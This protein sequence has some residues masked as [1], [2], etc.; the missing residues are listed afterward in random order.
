MSNE[1]TVW[2]TGDKIIASKLNNTGDNIEAL[3]EET[4]E[5][6]EKIRHELDTQKADKTELADLYIQTDYLTRLAKENKKINDELNEE[7]S[8]RDE[9]IAALFVDNDRITRTF[10][11]IQSDIA[12]LRDHVYEHEGELNEESESFIRDLADVKANNVEVENIAIDVD[13]AKRNIEALTEEVRRKVDNEPFSALDAEV[14][15]IQKDV[16]DLKHVNDNISIER[17]NVAVDQI[18][19]ALENKADKM[20][21]GASRYGE[22]GQLY[23]QVDENKRDIK[24]KVGVDHLAAEIG[25]LHVEADELKRSNLSQ[26]SLISY[27]REGLLT[28]NDNIAAKVPKPFIEGQSGQLLSTNGDGTTTWITPSPASDEQI[29]TAVSD[30]LD[31]HPDAT[32][33][34]Q[35]GSITIDK[36][37]PELIDTIETS[38]EARDASILI[39][40]IQSELIAQRSI[41]DEIQ[42]YLLT[43]EGLHGKL[44]Q[45]AGMFNGGEGIGFIFFTDP[46]CIDITFNKSNEYMLKNLREIRTV[47]ENS[48]AR[49]ILCGGDWINEKYTYNQAKLYS[50]RIVNLMRGWLG[51]RSYTCV[52]NHDLGFTTGSSRYN[53][54]DEKELANMWYGKNVGYFVIE[55]G[56]ADCY[57]LDSGIDNVDSTNHVVLMYEYRWIQL[58]WFA[59]KLLTN[60]SKH[61]FGAIHIPPIFP[62]TSG[63][64]ENPM[65]INVCAIADAF[66]RRAS[67]TINEN[68][69]DFS[70]ATGTFHF[71]V[72]GHIHSDRNWTCNNI[73]VFSSRAHL[74]EQP[75]DCCYADF[76]ASVLHMLRIG[77]GNSRDFNIIPSGQYQVAAG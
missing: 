8:M 59:N 10:D 57:V 62:D 68:T 1:R 56:N 39:N 50:G 77:G 36:L 64:T 16:E 28:A 22:V 54:S 37:S 76:D 31:D 7:Y 65:T 61:L 5:N 24:R 23:L 30:W 73:P 38:S 60:K 35:D 15:I 69:Y 29:G 11:G 75:I 55:D 34:V 9:K 26:D 32:T 43:F 13:K 51:E 27:V 46:H 45:Y 63:E 2:V 58:D 40:S 49:Y 3:K 72:C 52:G 48:P 67:I 21:V 44:E 42:K 4:E 18:E 41:E 66:N 17:L 74:D 25:A 14:D 71:M 33:T 12:E 6:F 70:D 53:A 47:F 20:E 19:T